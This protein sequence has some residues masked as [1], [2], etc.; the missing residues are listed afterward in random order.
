M[1]EI[2]NIKLHVLLFQQ[3][4]SWTEI[5]LNITFDIFIYTIRSIDLVT[6]LHVVLNYHETETDYIT[7]SFTSYLIENMVCCYYNYHLVMCK[8]IMFVYC[9]N[10]SDYS[11]TVCGQY[12]EFLVLI[13][14]AHR[15]IYCSAFKL[16]TK[17]KYKI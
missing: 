14:A 9:K 12:L 1:H 16:P 4:D 2:N 3:P 13:L 7:H 17:E 6:P 5:Y 15:V 8:K 10:H 11:G